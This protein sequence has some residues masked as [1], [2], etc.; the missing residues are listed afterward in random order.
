[1]SLVPKGRQ[2]RRAN[3]KRL[4]KAYP[5]IVDRDK[6]REVLDAVGNNYEHAAWVCETI[7]LAQPLFR[8]GDKLDPVLMAKNIAKRK[9]WEPTL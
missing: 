2:M 4:A 9:G 5:G 7:K 1:M 6:A 3:A 8:D